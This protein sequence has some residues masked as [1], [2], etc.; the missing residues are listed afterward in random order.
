MNEKKMNKNENI[1]FANFQTITISNNLYR[2]NCFTE[3]QRYLLSL[4]N[5]HFLCHFLAISFIERQISK[6]ISQFLASK[7]IAVG[8]GQHWGHVPP[9]LH[10]LA[11]KEV[12]FLFS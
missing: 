3:K 8:T 7:N 5:N 10:R 1:V 12:S 2:D 4:E 11:N 9:P 6:G